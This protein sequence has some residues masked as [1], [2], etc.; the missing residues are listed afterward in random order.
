MSGDDLFLMILL[1]GFVLVIFLAGVRLLAKG[2]WRLLPEG[3]LKR[4]LF[5][6]LPG[7][8]KR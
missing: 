7:H 3:R 5:A 2:I 4:I 8:R 1:K 6:P